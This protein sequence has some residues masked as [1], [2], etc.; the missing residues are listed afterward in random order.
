MREGWICP[1]CRRGVS[2][3]EK[4]CDHGGAFAEMYRILGDPR[5]CFSAPAQPAPGTW[6]PNTV[7]CGGVTAQADP[8]VQ[9]WS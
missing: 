7:F 3:D 1:Q 6:Q 2:P 4:H 9:V 5:D 8:R